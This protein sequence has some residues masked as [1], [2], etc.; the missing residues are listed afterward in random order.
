MTSNTRLRRWLAGGLRLAAAGVVASG[1]GLAGVGGARPLVRTKV[2]GEAALACAV[3]GR[4]LEE[5][6]GMATDHRLAGAQAALRSALDAALDP[7]G[8]R[9]AVAVDPGTCVQHLFAFALLGDLDAGHR[10]TARD[11]V[12]LGGLDDPAVTASSTAAASATASSAVA[13]GGWTCLGDAPAPFDTLERAWLRS[14]A[15]GVT[16]AVP[17]P[18]GSVL[19]RGADLLTGDLGAAYGFT[20]AVLH[21]TDAGRVRVSAHRPPSD[22]VDDAEALLGAALASGN[23]DITGE[24]LWTWPMLGLP[25]GPSAE[26]ALRVIAAAA[27]S[28]GFV[29]GPEHDPSTAAALTSRARS[30]YVVQTSYHTAVVTAVLAAT[31]LRLVAPAPAARRAPPNSA[32]PICLLS[33]PQGTLHLRVQ[34]LSPAERLECTPLLLGARLRLDAAHG[35][36][37]DLRDVVAWAL[38]QGWSDLPSVRQAAAL[39]RRVTLAGGGGPSGGG[40]DAAVVSVLSD[41]RVTIGA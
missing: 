35:D 3:T 4:L 7:A 36:L 2:L 19:E 25:F 30:T 5:H 34:A 38:G 18:V 12:N 6:P 20:H 29:P 31:A 10:S 16:G 23:L 24:L 15:A 32:D 13:S 27:D 11:L 26:L 28:L 8:A 41:P 14:L 22:L 9:V 40:G 17:V 1:E 37:A 39:L 33:P 21:A